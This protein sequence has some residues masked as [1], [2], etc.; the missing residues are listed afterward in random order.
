MAMAR[1]ALRRN[2]Q[3]RQRGNK[4]LLPHLRPRH[5]TGH[6]L[7]LGGTHDHGRLRIPEANPIPQRVLHRHRPRQTR[8]QDVQVTRQLARP[9]RAHREVRRGRRTHGH[10]ARRSCRQ[11]HPLRRLPLRT[12]HELLQQDVER[13]PTR[14][15]MGEGR[16][17][18]ACSQRQGHPMDES[19][20]KGRLRQD[21]RR[22]L[23]VPSQRGSHDSLQ[24]LYRR[25]LRMVSRNDKACL[26]GSYRQGH[27]RCHTRHLRQTAAHH[28][29]LH[30]IHHR[31]T[32]AAHRRTQA[33]RVAHGQR[34]PS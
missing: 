15:G 20:D 31:G 18:A 12:G 22:L 9:P 2:Q 26:P 8:T 17:T 30:A 25:V 1:I 28:T 11:R 32:L 13:L 21:K 23:Q 6:H 24:T 19:K 10:D 16:H 29:P 3:P 7:L 14:T 34:L 5:R 27:T 33:R 4:L